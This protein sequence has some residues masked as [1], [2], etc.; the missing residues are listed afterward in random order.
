MG[1]GLGDGVKGSGSGFSQER[2]ELGEHLLDGIEVGRVFWQED[3]PGSGGSDRLSHRLSFVRAEI[4]EN[5]DVARLEGRKEELLDI[6]QKA[7]AIDGAVEQAGRFDAVV[8][9]GGQEGRGLPKANAKRS[10]GSDRAGLWRSV[11]RRA[12]PSR[13]GASCWSWPRSRR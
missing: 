7:F 3:E 4:V 13:R 2:F 1:D 11:A 12:A 5:D 8:A 6:G 9:Q 10:S